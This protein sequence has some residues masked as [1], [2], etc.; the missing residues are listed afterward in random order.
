MITQ[1]RGYHRSVALSSINWVSGNIYEVSNKIVEFFK[2]TEANRNLSNENTLLLNRVTELENQLYTFTDSLSSNEWKKL[3]ITP[4]RDYKYIPAKVI[5]ITTN[6]VENYITLN[7][8]LKDGIKTDMGVV[9]DNGIVG[10]VDKVSNNFSRV[11]PLLHPKSTVI[12]KFKKN[13]YFG[14]LIWN[15]KDYRYAKLNDIA[16]HVKFSLGDTLL[17]GGFKTFPEGVIVGTIDNF[18]LKESEQYYDIDVKLAVDF[19]T[20]THVKVVDYK[21]YEEQKELEDY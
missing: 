13:N 19:K 14:P 21:N 12:S 7:K 10:V 9:A 15:G 18:E 6:Q 11:Q 5:R 8:G 1:N 2:L 17:T 16:R 4:E 3:E 20:L